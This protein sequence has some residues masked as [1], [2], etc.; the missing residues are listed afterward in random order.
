MPIKIITDSGADLP[1]DL[2]ESYD[3]EVV[4]FKV[5]IGEQ[6]YLDGQTLDHGHLMLAMKKGQT[7]ST[8]QV[9]WMTFV[10]VFENY[11]D[12]G[13][14]VLYIGF[15]SELSGT[16]DAASLAISKLKEENPAL[17]IE[18]LD[19]K[20]ASLGQGLLTLYAAELSGEMS[21]EEL[22][23]AIEKKLLAVHHYYMVGDLDYL[24][25]GGRLSKSQQTV[26]QLLKLKLLLT[27]DQGKLVLNSKVRGKKKA[28]RSM[29]ERALEDI[30]D[31]SNTSIGINYGTT[32]KEADELISLLESHGPKRLIKHPIGS[33]IGAHTG[34]DYL[35]LF[36]MT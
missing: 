36:Y 22:K 24:Y 15:S 14:E 34:P 19:S 27:V 33:A 8:G 26:G 5:L 21:L 12:Q 10:D 13:F 3:I 1:K 30:T 25:R 20:A 35:G 18:S 6:T 29:Y 31:F 2:V 17:K 28:I 9:T 23:Q 11:L 16:F 32:E 4:P 7:V